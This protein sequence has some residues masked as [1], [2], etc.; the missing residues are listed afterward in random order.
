MEQLVIQGQQ[1]IAGEL[2]VQGSKNLTLPILCACLLIP[3]PVVLTH[4]PMISDVEETTE[5]LRKLGVF[6]QREGHTILCDA[7]QASPSGLTREVTEGNRMSIL[8]L[9]A[10]VSRFGFGKI[11]YPGGCRIGKRPVNLHE[12]VLERFGTVLEVTDEGMEGRRGQRNGC[13]ISLPFP[14]VGATENAVLCACLSDGETEI[15]GA[16]RE[17]EITGLCRFLNSAGAKIQGMGTSRLQISGVKCLHGT[18]FEIEADRIVAGTYLTAAA[19][20]GGECRLNGVCPEQLGSYLE[21]LARLGCGLH[22]QEH[23]VRLT[24]PLRLTSQLR[25]KTEPYPGFPT[26]LQPLAVG[27]LSVAEGDAE[28][29]ESIFESRFDAAEEMRRFGAE[30]QIAPPGIRIHGTRRLHGAEV[31]G[32]DLRGTAALLVT[33]LAAEGETRLQGVR[34]LRRGYEDII[35]DLTA[36]GCT[37]IRKEAKEWQSYG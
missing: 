18:G 7:S 1:R 28:I 10:M 14:S 35:R 20:T 4:C 3:E 29:E 11:A 23:S 25:I 34:Y 22:L 36:L 17:P 6:V 2:T 12:M 33:A 16:A 5:M 8:M 30:L 24:A 13:R 15:T 31:T 32:R 9:G 19:I 37:G 27:A 26:D 21:F